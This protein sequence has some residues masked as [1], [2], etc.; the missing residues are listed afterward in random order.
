MAKTLFEKI[1]D[2]EIPATLVHEDEY[3]VAFRDINPGAPVHILLVPRKPI[4]RLCDAGADDQAVL[5]HLMLTASKIAAAEGH[6]EA[7]RLVVNNGAE[8]GQSVF[9]LHLHILAGRPLHWPPG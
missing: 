3:C 6:G 2:K 9:H 5:G 8:A 1:I 7:Y 4:P